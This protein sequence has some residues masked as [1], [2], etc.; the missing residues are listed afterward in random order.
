MNQAATI[1]IPVECLPGAVQSNARPHVHC[2][3]VLKRRP[4]PEPA[5]FVCT[6]RGQLPVDSSDLSPGSSSASQAHT[7]H[8]VLPASSSASGDQMQCQ[9][10]INSFLFV[11]SE[12]LQTLINSTA[13]YVGKAGEKV[14][15]PVAQCIL[16]YK[17]NENCNEAYYCW[18]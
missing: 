3:C 10:C 5:P 1:Y 4:A 17:F 7:Q 13:R 9:V 15:A 6:A 8:T 14:R 18:S 2:P 16:C 12:C 11:E